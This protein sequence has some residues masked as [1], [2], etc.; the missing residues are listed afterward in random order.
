MEPIAEILASCLAE[1]RAEE[2]VMRQIFD[3]W[4]DAEIDRLLAL[5]DAEREI[6]PRENAL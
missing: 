6:A 3:P 4:T 5:I 2:S 1:L